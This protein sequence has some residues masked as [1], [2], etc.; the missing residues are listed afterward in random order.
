MMS[1]KTKYALKALQRL[2]LS[3]NENPVLIEE[4]ASK[5]NIPRKFLETILLDLKHAGMVKSKMGKG[6]GYYLLRAAEE[7]SIAEV[8]RLFHGAIALLPCVSEKYYERCDDCDDEKT[9][10]LRMMFAEIRE[11][12]YDKMEQNTIAR[13]VSLKLKKKGK[14]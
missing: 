4:I 10:A 3:G 9:C 5:E 14:K 2:A 6:G 11:A 13:L 7:I 12:T 8:Y 1:K